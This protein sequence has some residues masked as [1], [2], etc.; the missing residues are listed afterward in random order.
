MC[1]S[2]DHVGVCH[3]LYVVEVTGDN[4]DDATTTTKMN[5]RMNWR[6]NWWVSE[7]PNETKQSEAKHNEMKRKEMKWN[8]RMNEHGPLWFQAA[9]SCSWCRRIGIRDIP[10][11]W[12]ETHH[13][14][15]GTCGVWVLGWVILVLGVKPSHE[16]AMKKITLHVGSC[17][18]RM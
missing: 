15:L 14:S 12:W 7:W 8:E 16:S 10:V 1:A 5:M 17:N 9:S 11:E 3:W 6:M 13:C 2:P 18:S 4:G